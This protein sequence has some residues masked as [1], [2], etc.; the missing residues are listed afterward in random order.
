MSNFTR[1]IPFFVV[2]TPLPSHKQ[3]F[4]SCWVCPTNIGNGRC[5]LTS[6]VVSAEWP[7]PAFSLLS[8]WPRSGP[9]QHSHFQRGG[10]GVA[11]PSIITFIATT[12]ECE[13]RNLCKL[14]VGL[15]LSLSSS[16]STSV[17]FVLYSSRGFC[18][19]ACPF[20]ARERGWGVADRPMATGWPSGGG[21]ERR[22]AAGEL[23]ATEGTRG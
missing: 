20:V 19:P 15:S 3:V 8:W 7:D 5:I 17:L 2:D 12:A 11:R 4:L 14:G 1:V 13:I 16:L 21:R 10:R 23:L 6:M 9:T 18:P 22:G